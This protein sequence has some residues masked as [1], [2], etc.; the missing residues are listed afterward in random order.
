VDIHRKPGYDPCEL[1]VDPAIRFPRLRVASRLARKALG[2]RYRMDV[3]PL[4]AS[5]VR[6]SHGLPARDPADGPVL[7]SDD[8]GAGAAAGALADLKSHAL[9]LWR[10]A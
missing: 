4:D 3:V 8:P 1:L 9:A 2:F 10:E 7:V 6:G 5:L